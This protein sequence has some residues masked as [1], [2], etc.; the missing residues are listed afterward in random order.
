MPTTKK[1]AAKKTVVKKAAKKRAAP[2][3][4]AFIV[5]AV[6]NDTVVSDKT[7]SIAEYI[8]S[9]APPRLNTKLVV[10]VALAGSSKLPAEFVF[11]AANARR[12]FTNRMAA[13]I[14]EKRAKLRLG[15]NG[16]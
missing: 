3:K 13:V 1:R 5:E 16:E 9:I 2:A 7:D 4:G 14:L 12:I 6:F 15:Y 11:M 10:R 8:H